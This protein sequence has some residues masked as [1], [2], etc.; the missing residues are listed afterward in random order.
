MFKVCS[1]QSGRNAENPY[2]ADDEDEDIEQ[3][4]SL[5]SIDSIEDYSYTTPTPRETLAMM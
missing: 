3:W 5:N 2:V 1:L 4:Q